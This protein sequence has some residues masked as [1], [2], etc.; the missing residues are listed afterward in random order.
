M[1]KIVIHEWIGSSNLVMSFVYHRISCF[2]EGNLWTRN[3]CRTMIR[4]VRLTWSWIIATHYPGGFSL[5]LS[6]RVTTVNAFLL[7]WITPALRKLL[8]STS[9]S[10]TT[11]TLMLVCSLMISN[12]LLFSLLN[13]IKALVSELLLCPFD[14]CNYGVFISHMSI[15][16]WLIVLHDLLYLIVLAML[17]HLG[18]ENFAITLIHQGFLLIVTCSEATQKCSYLSRILMKEELSTR[19]RGVINVVVHVVTDVQHHM[20]C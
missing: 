1:L 7:R 3:P 4:G 5:S 12:C 13:L 11:V 6:I 15:K 8:L 14:S 17:I 2:L 10:S 19:I 16:H 20:R 18:F 9:S